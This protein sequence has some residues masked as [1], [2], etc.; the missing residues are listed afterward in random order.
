MPVICQIQS[1]WADDGRIYFLQGS[2]QPAG[3]GNNAII[4]AKNADIPNGI[5]MTRHSCDMKFSYLSENFTY[6]LKHETRSLIG[7]SFYC[8]V[9]PTD[10]N[11]V[12][13][14][15]RE[16]LVKGH[17][18]TPYYRLISNNGSIIWLQ[19]EA[20]AVSHTSK[21]RKG[22]IQNEREFLIDSNQ[23]VAR[24]E[25]PFNEKEDSSDLRKDYDEVLQF[26]RHQPNNNIPKATNFCSA[27]GQ[28]QSVPRKTCDESDPSLTR[29]TVFVAQ[30]NSPE[31]NTDD[32]IY[33]NNSSSP[34]AQFDYNPLTST[35]SV[36]EPRSPTGSVTNTSGIRTVQD[37]S[38]IVQNLPNN[39]CTDSLLNTLLLPSVSGTYPL[40]NADVIHSRSTGTTSVQST[41]PVISAR[42]IR[43][44]GYEP[45]VQS[46]V[47]SCH[48]PPY[49]IQTANNAHTKMENHGVF[50]S[51][52]DDLPMLAPFIAHDDV[53][54]L[55]TDLHGLLP[56]YSITEWMLSDPLSLQTTLGV[57]EDCSAARTKSLAE[58]NTIS[59]LNSPQSQQL[60]FDKFSFDEQNLA[61][62]QKSAIQA[63]FLNSINGQTIGFNVGPIS[64]R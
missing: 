63:A 42:Y 10:I 11:R 51:S 36:I 29:A 4:A 2:A 17:S 26:F 32:L 15:I 27:E 37:C 64:Q 14:S 8:L 30:L 49:I 7:T 19:T 38:D 12:A 58:V 18:Q 6:I 34:Y 55:T 43:S 54:Q 48:N 21:G 9:F 3:Q 24:N 28:M 44:L 45:F 39:F 50:K 22:Q 57:S 20:T 31:S 46:S 52:G 62:E 33:G 16:M 35:E 59:E 41:V 47:A 23:K 1:I 40:S 13:S 53:M 60:I 61:H 56:D 25:A 5:F